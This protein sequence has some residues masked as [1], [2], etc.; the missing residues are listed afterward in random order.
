MKALSYR[1][2]TDRTIA[3]IE[4]CHA[5]R[6]AEAVKQP[7]RC[8]SLEA[9]WESWAFGAYLLWSDLTSCTERMKHDE[10]R[11]KAMVGLQP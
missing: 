8:R 5:Q 9:A 4:F 2:I 6:D 7:D 10:A 11:I 1:Q 3:H